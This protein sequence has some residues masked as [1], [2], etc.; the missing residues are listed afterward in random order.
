[1]YL[2]LTLESLSLAINLGVPEEER[3]QQQ[4]VDLDLE[5]R[6]KD[7]TA[8]DTD[9]VMDTICYDGLSQQICQFSA[10]KQFR[11]IEYYG[12]QLF[13]YVKTLLPDSAL[14]KLTVIKSPPMDNLKKANFCVSD[15]Q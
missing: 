7:L 3:R 13:E 14:L 1:M 4:R 12:Y 2:S 6:L 11:L 15:W 9:D 5:I 10:Q 8:V